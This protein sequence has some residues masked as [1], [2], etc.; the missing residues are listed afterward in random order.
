MAIFKTQRL[1]KFNI[2]SITTINQRDIR[3]GRTAALQQR[4]AAWTTAGSNT[5]TVAGSNT[6]APQKSMN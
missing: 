1:N 2:N 5:W 3:T 6:K 4:A